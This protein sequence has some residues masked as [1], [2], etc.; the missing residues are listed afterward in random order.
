[1]SVQEKDCMISMLKEKVD[2]LKAKLTR[3]EQEEH[4]RENN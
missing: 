1:M 4:Q 2:Q 3:R